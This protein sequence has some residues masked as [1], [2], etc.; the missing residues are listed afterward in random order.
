MNKYL[1]LA[2]YYT[3]LFLLFFIFSYIYY[4]NQNNNQI[5]NNYLLI[6]NKNLKSKIDESP[7]LDYPDYHTATIFLGN[8]YNQHTFFI[9][10]NYAAINNLPVLNEFGLI[11]LT[12]NS[13]LNLTSNLSLS[14]ILNNTYA[15]HENH[16]LTIPSNVKIEVGDPVYTSGLT[17]IPA[18]ILVGYVKSFYEENNTFQVTLEYL[19]ITSPSCLILTG[20]K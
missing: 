17:S 11:G 7:N 1:N 16:Y 3:F 2:L 15:I 19:P 12:S 10:S 13:T 4:T 6:E 20:A 8:L 14:V 18:H 9:K 5:L